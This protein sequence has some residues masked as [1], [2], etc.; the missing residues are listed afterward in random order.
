M[1]LHGGKLQCGQC[2]SVFELDTEHAF[3]CFSFLQYFVSRYEHTPLQ[4]SR[5]PD[6]ENVHTPLMEKYGPEMLAFCGLFAILGDGNPKHSMTV[7]NI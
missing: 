3:I 4:K 1:D 2:R 7:C 5:T 6:S